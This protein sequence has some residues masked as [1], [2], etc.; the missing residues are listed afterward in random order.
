MKSIKSVHKA[1]D[2]LEL[3]LK[4]DENVNLA[5]ITEKSGM[6]KSTV[7]RFL[8]TLVERGYLKQAGKRGKY[9]MGTRFLDFSSLIKTRL[10]IRDI[11]LPHISK[12][13]TVVKENVILSVP[14]GKYARHLELIPSQ[15]ILNIRP[16]DG[17]RTPLYCTGVGKI[18]LASMSAAEIDSYFVNKLEPLTPNTITR[19]NTLKAQLINVADEGVAYD[20][21][22]EFEGVRNVAAAIM[23]SDGKVVAAIGVLGPSIRMTRSHL[24]EI[25]PEVKRCAL[26]ISH[27]LGYKPH[28]ET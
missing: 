9:S 15:H 8:Y 24:I 3:F 10:K 2:L 27:D 16:L 18:F 1:F 28:G 14:D 22:E 13:A 11:A 25:T 5:E 20:D 4:M 12:L 6:D 23:D 7:N 17:A 26:N 21:E 19:I